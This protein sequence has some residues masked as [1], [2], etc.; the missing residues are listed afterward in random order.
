MLQ[1]M[2]NVLSARAPAVASAPV[3]LPEAE[4]AR[5]ARRG[6]QLEIF[7]VCWAALEASV[8]LVGAYREHS[9]SLA[10]FGWDSCIEML[11]GAALYW[12]MTH[13][14]NHDRKHRAET[15]SLKLAGWCLYALAVYVLIDSVYSLLRGGASTP[16]WTGMAITAAALVS[17]PLLTRAKRT[18]GRGLNSRAMMADAKQTNFCAIQAGIVLGGL[19]VR[20]VFHVS[21]ADGVA[22]LVLLPFLWRAARESL[23]GNACC[24]H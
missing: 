3:V 11:S 14:M 21:W 19:L 5:L 13:E 16:G 12:R 18:V 1:G 15:V 4:R 7:T 10:G 8:A 20:S 2:A 23:R 6:R 24:S 22:G 9:I 17:M